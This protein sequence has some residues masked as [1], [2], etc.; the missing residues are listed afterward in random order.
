[1]KKGQGVG[2]DEAEERLNSNLCLQSIR[3][4]QNLRNNCKR[5]IPGHS[6]AKKT[7]PYVKDKITYLNA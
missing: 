3:T 2:W 5:Y 7:E 1:M 6:H 4:K